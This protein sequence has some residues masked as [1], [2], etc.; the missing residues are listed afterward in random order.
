MKAVV[1]ERYGPPEVLELREVPKPAPKT[2]EVLVRVHATSVTAG[3]WRMRSANP[4]LVRLFN[5]LFKPKKVSIL[6]FE[7]SGV[8]EQVGGDVKTFARGDEVF[9]FC[10]LGFG[11]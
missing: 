5:G 2:G 9:A 6:G 10:G 11:G 7:L 4:F 1:Y 3:D 8:I